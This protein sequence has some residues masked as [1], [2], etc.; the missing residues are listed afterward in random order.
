MN[1]TF[2]KNVTVTLFGES[3]GKAIG[4]V[5][6]GIAP[7][8]PVDETDIAHALSLRRGEAALS[9]PRRKNHRYPPD[10]ADPKR[11]HPKRRL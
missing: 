11:R 1:N 7:G 9:T 5:L 8:I 10:C 4:A 3:H 2:G 6:D